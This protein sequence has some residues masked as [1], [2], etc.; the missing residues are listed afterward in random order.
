MFIGFF[1]FLVRLRAGLSPSPRLKA[2]SAASSEIQ[3]KLKLD[4][5][6]FDWNYCA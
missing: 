1:C 5:Q 4:L 3:K 6:A 2:S